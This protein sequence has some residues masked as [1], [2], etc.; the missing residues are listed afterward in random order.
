MKKSSKNSL[1]FR[2]RFDELHLFR[3]LTEFHCMDPKDK[4][5]LMTLYPLKIKLRNDS[6]LT[7]LFA[8]TAEL[9][10]VLK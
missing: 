6:K 9:E 10:D 3:V 2:G 4:S 7:L 8:E 5:R 1:L